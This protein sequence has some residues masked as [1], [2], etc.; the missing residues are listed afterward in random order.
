MKKI[1]TIVI[2]VA[3]CVG[4]YFYVNHNKEI[5]AAEAT[6]L[7]YEK[8]EAVQAA[9]AKVSRTSAVRA[10]DNQAAWYIFDLRLIEGSDNEFHKALKKELG[11]EFNTQLSTGDYIFVGVLPTYQK[12]RVYAGDP[13]IESSMI[14]PDW[15]YEK[16]EKR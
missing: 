10:Y 14:Y 9:M 6:N 12:Y 13:N 8:I 7:D 1:L 5:K 2:I 4:I 3:A 15:K 16:L 11:D